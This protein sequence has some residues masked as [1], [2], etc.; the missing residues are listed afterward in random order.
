EGEGEGAE[1]EGEGAEGEGE[2]EG[3]VPTAHTL[4]VLGQSDVDGTT[5]VHAF[6]VSDDGELTPIAGSPFSTPALQGGW[7]GDAEGLVSDGDGH[8]YASGDE[9]IAE[10]AIAPD[11]SL[12]SLP[13]SPFVTGVEAFGLAYDPVRRVVYGAVCNEDTPTLLA[14]S[15]EGDASLGSLDGAPFPS[16]GIC[17]DSVILAPD[18]RTAWVTTEDATI[19]S[20]SLDNSGVPTLGPIT[21]L[22]DGATSS[23]ARFDAAN[24]RLFVGDYTRG[25]IYVFDVDSQDALTQVAG[26]PFPSSVTSVNGLALVGGR[27]YG[28][29]SAEDAVVA[30]DIDPSGALTQIAA[31][32]IALSLGDA[33]VLLPFP[34]GSGLFIA[35]DVS[36][37]LRSYRID[38]D[39]GLQETADSPTSLVDGAPSSPRALL[40]LDR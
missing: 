3:E 6:D 12:T 9:S 18:R 2:G 8:L 40:L 14:L 25:A 10:L 24:R 30:Y 38:D 33:S 21:L 1:G 5:I 23:A 29:G 11:G 15:V 13:G 16:V 20:F 36:F 37:N 26:S 39:G 17:D 32:P 34:D 31:S 4:Y 19:A 22:D 35:D 28:G 7:S 27:L